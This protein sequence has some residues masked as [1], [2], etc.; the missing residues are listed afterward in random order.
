MPK[1]IYSGRLAV[2]TCVHVA[3]IDEHSSIWNLLK[4]GKVLQPR[5]TYSSARV[6][7][8]IELIKICAK[9]NT[10]ILDWNYIINQ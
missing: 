5:I 7:T 6:A 8:I 10:S 9:H 3:E 4:E 2:A 1:G